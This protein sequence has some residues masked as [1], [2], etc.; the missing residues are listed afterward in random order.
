[1]DEWPPWFER[2]FWIGLV[3]AGIAIDW[4]CA[5]EWFS[6]RYSF[7]SGT[8]V[9]RM[10]LIVLSCAAIGFLATFLPNRDKRKLSVLMFF[11]ASVNVSGNLLM[12]W[13]GHRKL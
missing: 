8:V 3:T 4:Y 2:S 7:W 10:V 13:I 9:H 6:R 12:S 5:F 11:F 1:M